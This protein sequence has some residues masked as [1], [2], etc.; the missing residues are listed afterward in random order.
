MLILRYSNFEANTLDLHLD[1]LRNGSVW[2][3]WW[4]KSHED[5]PLD[6][7]ARAVERIDSGPLRIGLIDRADEEY[8]VALCRT[9]TVDL[10]GGYLPSPD[11]ERT[12]EYYAT[13]RC[14]AWFEFVDIS[15]V[16]AQA[17]VAEFGPVPHGDPTIFE[18]RRPRPDKFPTTVVTADS[19]PGRNGVLHLSDLHFGS[20]HGYGF[21]NNHAT[22]PPVALAEKVAASLV[23]KPAIVVVSGDLTTRG[24]YDG[25]LAARHFLDELLGLLDVSCEATVILPGNHDILLEDPQVTRDFSNEQAFRDLLQVFYGREM[26]LERV[27]DVRDEEGRHYIVGTLN[28][29][30]PRYRATMDYGYVGIDRSQPVFE[31]VR[32]CARLA[33]SSVWAAVSLHHHVLPGPPVEELETARPEAARPV[34]ITL[35]AGEIVSLAQEYGIDALLHGHQHLPFIGRVSRIAEFTPDGATHRKQ[36]PGVA[37]LGAGSAGTKRVPQEVGLN[38]YSVYQP[39]HRADTT[40]VECFGYLERRNVHRLWSFE[41]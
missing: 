34:S 26:P 4:K 13:K 22:V 19:K 21:R 24:E 7:F 30:R 35:D 8:S 12:P 20:D 16:D 37:V 17:W 40:L 18:A 9:I 1:A 3:G 11:L 2:W 29:S 25:L 39:F 14:A 41:V 5:F 23:V 15:K 31:S 10:E 28:S 32:E 27:H 36:S 38:T 6:L 33:R